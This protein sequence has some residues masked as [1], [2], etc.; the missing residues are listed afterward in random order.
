MSVCLGVVDTIFE[1][2]FGRVEVVIGGSGVF[3][4]TDH[5]EVYS[6][7]AIGREESSSVG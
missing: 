2:F 7:T 3:D 4:K 1:I 5:R 6:D